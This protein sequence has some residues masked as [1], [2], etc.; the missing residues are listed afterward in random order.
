MKKRVNYNASTTEED[1]DYESE[2]GKYVSNDTVNEQS[3]KAI[4]SEQLQ[5]LL[6]MIQNSKGKEKAINNTKEDSSATDKNT[7]KKGMNY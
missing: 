3:F 2:R 1:R 5:H 4:N 6:D 7:G